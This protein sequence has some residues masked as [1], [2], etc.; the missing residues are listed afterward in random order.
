MRPRDI[1]KIG[2]MYAADGTWNGQQIVTSDWVEESTK[3]R[4]EITPET[5][6][7][8]QEAFQNNYFGGSQAYI[9]GVNRVE[10]DERSYTSYQASGN[11]GQL[12]IVVP[13]LD[14]VVGITGGNCRMGGIWGRWRDQI[15]GTYI[16]R[17]IADLP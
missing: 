5:T 6:G 3:A 10:V 15:V 9:W 4:I 2:A 16:I 8:T 12:L 1:L 17:A 13:D 7:M 14:L 11:G